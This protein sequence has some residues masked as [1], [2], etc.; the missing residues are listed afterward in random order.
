SV[1][2]VFFSLS[3]VTNGVLQ[4]INRMQTPL[5][6]A[7]ISLV[8]HVIILCIML[9]GFRMGIYSVVY[10]NILFALTMCLLNGAAIGRFLNY[11]QEIKK[12]F[13]IPI[14]ASG[15]M[16][17]AA[18]GT[19]FLV[20][21]TLKRNAISVLAAIAIAVVVYGILLLKLRCVDEAELLNVPG[22]KKLVRIA[23]KFHLM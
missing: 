2:V 3:T 20:H 15:V 6:N 16:G 7:I 4:G 22:G 1:A 8:L 19:Y 5:K 23:R 13:I 11:R 14:L 18:Y 17:A 21:L 12:T 9:F 10:S